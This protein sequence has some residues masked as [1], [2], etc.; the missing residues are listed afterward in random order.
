MTPGP[1]CNINP[2]GGLC[3]ITLTEATKRLGRFNGKRVHPSTVFRWTR[4][5][6]GVVLEH[7]RVGRKIVTTEAALQKF[8]TE[9]VRADAAG[10]P[11]T[12]APR[13]RR[14]HRHPSSAARQREVDAANDVL[15]RAG[16]LTDSDVQPSAHLLSGSAQ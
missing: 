14:P 7:W 3:F 2:E 9:L 8:F 15:R 4:G 13:K 6:R 1:E 5:L 12:P 11:A 10:Q 16:I